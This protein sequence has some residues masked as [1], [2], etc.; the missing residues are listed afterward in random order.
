MFNGTECVIW[1]NW[2]PSSPTQP[3]RL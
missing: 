1:H 2:Y 3:Y